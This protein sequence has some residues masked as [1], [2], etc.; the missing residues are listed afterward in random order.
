MSR[1]FVISGYRL[2]PNSSGTLTV[3]T[4][5]LFKAFVL[6]LTARTHTTEP[7]SIQ[8]LVYR[9]G[10][11]TTVKGSGRS[12]GTTTVDIMG[13]APDSG[14]EISGNRFFGGT[15]CDRGRRTRARSTG[16]AA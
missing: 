13:R 8:H 10:Y 15:P 4:L 2:C 1:A 5:G 6:A 7:T 11:N 14:L 12:T 3:K 9:F 16:P